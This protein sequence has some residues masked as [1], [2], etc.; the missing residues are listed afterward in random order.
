MQDICKWTGADL[1]LL[2]K[3]IMVNDTKDS[4][5]LSH[6]E[7]YIQLGSS[8]TSS[9]NS[10]PLGHARSGIGRDTFKTTFDIIHAKASPT[11][12]PSK[13]PQ[14]ALVNGRATGS[15]RFLQFNT[16]PSAAPRQIIGVE[17]ISSACLVQF[18]YEKSMAQ[19][20]QIAAHP[21]N[22]VMSPHH[23]DLSGRVLLAFKVVLAP[24]NIP[25]VDNTFGLPLE[26]LGLLLRA[27]RYRPGVSHQKSDLISRATNSSIRADK[28]PDRLRPVC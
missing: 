8:D 18:Q 24:G 3:S 19:S 16:D 25:P 20:D 6:K 28:R 21:F 7:L 13:H 26:S 4:T 10:P 11:Y 9:S 2:D 12:A 22:I 17:S 5:E 23:K 14:F 15:P 1:G 27:K